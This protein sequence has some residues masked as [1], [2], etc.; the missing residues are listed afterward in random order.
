MGLHLVVVQDNGMRSGQGSPHYIR[1]HSLDGLV[2]CSKGH[3]PDEQ[4]AAE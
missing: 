4:R 1:E 2:L 3:E